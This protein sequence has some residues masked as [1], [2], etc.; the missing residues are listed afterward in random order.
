MYKNENNNANGLKWASKLLSN[1]ITSVKGS[2][3]N[4]VLLYF[5]EKW[6]I[7]ELILDFKMHDKILRTTNTRTEVACVTSKFEREN[8]EIRKQTNSINP[9]ICDN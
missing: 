6:L 9:K 3:L 2:K 4:K 8:N 1:N 5:S 7:Y